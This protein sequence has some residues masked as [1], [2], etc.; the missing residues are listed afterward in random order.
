MYT[1]RIEQAIRAAAILHKDQIRK[2]TNPLPYITHLMAVAMIVRDYT[3]DEN[4]IISALLHDTLE[5]TD[6]TAAELQEDFG[7]EVR[8]IVEQISEPADN[9]EDKQAWLERKQSYAKKL[10]SAPEAALLVSAADKIHNMRS[11]VEEYFED[12]LRFNRDFNGSLDDRMLMYQDI[13]NVIN[14]RLE[15]DI[16][17][18][19][20]YVY[21]EYKNFILDVK[22]VVE[23]QTFY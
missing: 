10:R 11:V 21:T 12:H 13:G 20:N 9:G 17:Q 15:N 8:T 6:Y 4:T 23:R 14:S 3:D 2:G 18:E 1:Y 16:V 7:K 22:K 19:F 5:D